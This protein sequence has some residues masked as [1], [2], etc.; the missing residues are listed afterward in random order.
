MTAACNHFTSIHLYVDSIKNKDS[1]KYYGYTCNSIDDFN[2]GKCLKCSAKGCNKM[3]YWSSPSNDLGTTYLN[4]KNALKPPS[5]KQN[6][7]LYLHSA[8]NLSQTKGKFTIFF[9]TSKQTSSTE[10]LD[11]PESTF[12][13]GSVEQRLISLSEPLDTSSQIEN[14]YI[15]F[16]KT[17]SSLTGWLYDSSWSFDYIEILSGETQSLVKLCPQKPTIPTNEL[18]QFKKC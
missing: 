9:E 8:K 6:Y 1:C 5:C 7:L 3:G 18:V 16:E 14:A 12:K 2:S 15:F 4:T 13:A 17:K 11:D 10:L